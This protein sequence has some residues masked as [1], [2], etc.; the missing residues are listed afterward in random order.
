MF[1][2]SLF[3]EMYVSVSF[4]FDLHH[5]NPSPTFRTSYEVCGKVHR[6][7]FACCKRILNA[8]FLHK[9][10]RLVQSEAKLSFED[11]HSWSL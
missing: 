9:F 1:T 11:E 4:I 2:V 10:W 8:N 5:V 6:M 7:Q 3:I